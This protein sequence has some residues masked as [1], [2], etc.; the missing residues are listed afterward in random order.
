MG[1]PGDDPPMPDPAVKGEAEHH[2]PLAGDEV[3]AS[4]EAFASGEA[5]ASGAASPSNSQSPTPVKEVSSGEVGMTP[6]ATMS[7][8]PEL[9]PAPAR[10]AV[11]TAPQIRTYV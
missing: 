1:E 11:V 10:P 3:I 7:V 4:G 9:A 5:T 8:S 2:K 6:D